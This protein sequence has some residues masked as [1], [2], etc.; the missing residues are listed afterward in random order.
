LRSKNVTKE[1]GLSSIEGFYGEPKV[2]EA[3]RAVSRTVSQNTSRAFEKRKRKK[4]PF[5]D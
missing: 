3:K 4:P 1:E 2:S 5:A